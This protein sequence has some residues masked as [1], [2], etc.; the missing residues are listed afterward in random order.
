MNNDHIIFGNNPIENIVSI[1]IEDNGLVA[2]Q[3]FDG[4]I[5]EF[6]YDNAFW[7]LTPSPL[8]DCNKAATILAGNLHYKYAYTFSTKKDF[9]SFRNLL[10]KKNKDFYCINDDKEASMVRNG[11]TYFKGMSFKDVSIL[12]FDLETTG[13]AHDENSKIICIS[14]TYRNSKG[15][16]SKFLFSHDTNKNEGEMLLDFCSWVRE[17]NPSIILGHNINSFDL[18]YMH[19][20]AEQL[21]I[22]L[23]LGR[24]KSSLRFD[25]YESK[26]RKDG[27][28]FYHYNKSHIYGRNIVDTMFLSI[29]HD[30]AERK[31]ESYGLKQ[32]IKQLNLEK[33]GRVF[34]DAS[35]IRDNYKIPEEWKKIKAY[36]ID[37]S[38]DALNLY[39][40]VGPPAF[41][42][43]QSIPKSF[44]AVTE[45]ATGS[46]INSMMVRA[47]LQEKHSIPKGD[48][49][50]HYEGAISDSNPG[51]YHNCW[52]IDAKSM[53]PSI[54]LE[55][56]IEDKE[57]DPKGYFLKM[58]KYFTDER[59]K[60]KK[61]YEET[62]NKYYDDLQSTMKIFINSF[63][64]FLGASGL[65]FNSVKN[66]ALIT[67]IGRAIIKRTIL[68][69][70][71]KKYESKVS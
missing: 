43:T 21:N 22:E 48:N 13:L 30:A 50:E 44:Q 2:Y 8:N 27:S 61:I 70:T 53:Y 45:S 66:A 15:E 35:K 69:A 49:A 25:N 62:K 29:R 64:G 54:I 28:Q 59:F 3:E 9:Y 12:S 51:V 37:D 26:F 14:T 57:K 60:N 32:I 33:P 39:D 42:A 7:I 16:I 5:S 31:F 68:W 11:M 67:E 36:C 10:K 65:N 34:Y 52:K 17:K 19:Y 55:Y 47:Y 58:V 24:D 23:S 56:N 41:Y 18:P 6:T 71:G 20:R 40:V 46:Q 1:E 4:N 63:Y 38:D